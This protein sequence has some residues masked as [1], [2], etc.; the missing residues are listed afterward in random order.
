MKTNSLYP[1]ALSLLSTLSLFRGAYSH[2]T[3]VRRCITNGGIIRFYVKHWHSTLSNPSSAGSM[4]IRNEDDGTTV[5]KLPDGVLNNFAGTN[6]PDCNGGSTQVTVCSGQNGDDDWVYYNYVGVCDQPL[7]YTLLSGNTVVLTEA[8]SALYP[9]SIQTTFYDTDPPE[10]YVEGN[11][12]VG[13]ID[14]T[15]YTEY[16]QTTGAAFFTV[17]TT[18]DCDA[19]PDITVSHPTGTVFPLG[20][21]TVTVTSTDDNGRVTTCYFDVTMEEGSSQPSLLPSAMPSLLPSSFPSDLP[22]VTER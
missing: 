6:F 4:T 8:C 19:A 2:G 5:T 14:V 13:Q 7:H 15:G 20:T 9:A 22:T 12:C 1:F 16:G 11:E 17:T 18:D 3:E 10:I 21:T